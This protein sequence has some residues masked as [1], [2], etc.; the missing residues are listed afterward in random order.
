MQLCTDSSKIQDP[1][2]EP[3]PLTRNGKAPA[4][5]FPA[6]QEE[7]RGDE[8]MSAKSN[9]AFVFSFSYHLTTVLTCKLSKAHLNLLINFP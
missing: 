9:A 6:G 2:T 7:D 1:G 5:L 4:Y 3:L 8:I